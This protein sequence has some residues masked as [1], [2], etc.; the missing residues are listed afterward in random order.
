MKVRRSPSFFGSP[1]VLT[2]A[3]IA[4]AGCGTSENPSPK[5]GPAAV[6]L[7]QQN[8]PKLVQAVGQ[9][10]EDQQFLADNEVFQV[11]Q[12]RYNEVGRDDSKQYTREQKNAGRTLSIS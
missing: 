6:Q 4:G 7:V 8:Q 11:A 9:S 12:E 1:L 3:L 2:V 10:A 5:T